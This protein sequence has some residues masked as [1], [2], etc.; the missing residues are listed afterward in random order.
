MSTPH[1]EHVSP[2]QKKQSPGRANDQ[3][4]EHAT[5]DETIAQCADVG[6]LR[7]NFVAADRA[8]VRK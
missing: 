3:G 1:R 8:E 2:A 5:D 4:I 6:D 7:G